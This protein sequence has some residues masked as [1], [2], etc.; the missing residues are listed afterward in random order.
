MES[1]CTAGPDGDDTDTQNSSS[2]CFAFGPQLTCQSHY[3]RWEG[4]RNMATKDTAIVD[5]DER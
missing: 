2:V 3:M 1:T 5:E 4:D